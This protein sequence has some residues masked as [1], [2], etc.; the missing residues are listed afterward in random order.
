MRNLTDLRLQKARKQ[1]LAMVDK[2]QVN[3]F[4]ASQISELLESNREAWHLPWNL[5]LKRFIAFL[6]E[7]GVIE[8]VALESQLYGDKSV[9]ATGKATDLEIA[10]AFVPRA[11]FSHGTAAYLHGLTDQAPRMFYVNREQTEKRPSGTPLTQQ[12][13]DRAFRSQPRTSKFVFQFRD[14]RVCVISGKHTGKLEVGNIRGPAGEDLVATKLERTLVDLAVRPQY[15]GGV[16]EVL[17][18]YEAAKGR[19]SSNVIIATLKK[20]DYVYPYHQAIG[21]YM[22]RAGYPKSAQTRLKELGLQFGF[23]LVAGIKDLDYVEEWKLFVP[24]RL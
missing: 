17:A 22:A 1:I 18:A 5:G 21:F 12:A 4:K 15:A 23:Y 9:L 3:V 2:M 11:Y 13:I 24:K 14:K 6:I 8:E 10:I 20:L 16:H 19:A 7:T